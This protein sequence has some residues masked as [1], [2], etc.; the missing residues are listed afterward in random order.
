MSHIGAME[1]YLTIKR[2]KFTIG[3][4]WMDLEI[5]ILKW[6]KPNKER[7]VSYNI[8]HMWNLKK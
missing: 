4:T 5:F 7:Q 8:T 2:M 3:R 1:Y 6:S